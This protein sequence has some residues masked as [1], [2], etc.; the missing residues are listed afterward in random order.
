[1]SKRKATT[2]LSPDKIK[3]HN[4][5]TDYVFYNSATKTGKVYKISPTKI[6]KRP[7]YKFF[8]DV[9]GKYF[10]IQCLLNLGSTSFVLS[11]EA[12]KVFKIPV[13]KRTVQGKASD[14]GGR[15]IPTEGLFTVPLGISFGNHRTFDEKDHAFEVVKSTADYD[16]LIP[17][18]YLQK[19]QAQG[20]TTSHLYFPNCGPTCFGHGLLHPEYDITYDMRVALKPDAINIGAIVSDSPTLLE[21][22]PKHYHKWL[23]LFDPKEAEKLRS[24]KGWDHRIELKVPE[25]DLRMG[26][27]YQLLQEDEKL[28]IQ[29]IEKMSKEGKI[30][31]SLS[32]VGSP[33]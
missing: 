27:I 28:L 15:T 14:V 20:I 33:I 18:W 7:I 3:K 11:P 21:K 4:S 13:V 12:A 30:R 24:N 25:E 17:A 23:L 29:Y 10:P 26:P 32:S 5:S 2:E 6:G 8:I 16:A 31:P 1:M 22:L 9:N 19:H